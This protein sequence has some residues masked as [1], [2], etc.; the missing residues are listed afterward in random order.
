MTRFDGLFLRE[1]YRRYPL[2]VTCGC[3][4]I[5]K[6]LTIMSEPY[7]CHTCGETL[8]TAA[9]GPRLVTIQDMAFFR[10]PGMVGE[11]TTALCEQFR[12]A[13]EWVVESERR[14]GDVA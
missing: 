10:L 4:R 5:P 8:W 12:A 3:M 6:G 11:H 13:R 1:M 2:H 14:E 7:E 9:V